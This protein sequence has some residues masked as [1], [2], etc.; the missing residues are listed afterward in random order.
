MQDKKGLLPRT[1]IVLIV[2]IGML[3]VASSYWM[4]SW[5]DKYT[6]IESGE[7]NQSYNSIQEMA[8][9]TDTLE[10]KLQAETKATGIGFLDFVVQGGYNVLIAV[11]TVPNILRGFVIDAAGEFG[12]PQVYVDGFIILIAVGAIFGIL[13]AIFRRKT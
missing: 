1:W 3:V 12:I 6:P 13:G 4:T 9:V 8:S 2:I 7:I 5:N 10:S 11:L